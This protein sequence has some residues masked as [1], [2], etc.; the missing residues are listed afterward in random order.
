MLILLKNSE[1]SRVQLTIEVKYTIKPMSKI[2]EK[3]KVTSQLKISGTLDH[4]HGE[5][6]ANQSGRL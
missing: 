3:K 5:Q 4:V 1:E 2:L 6:M